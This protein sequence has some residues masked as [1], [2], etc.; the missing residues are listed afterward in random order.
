S[1]ENITEALTLYSV[2]NTVTELPMINRVEFLIDGES[3]RGYAYY[4]LTKPFTNSS[5]FLVE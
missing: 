3:V 1:H 4:D 5:E 2:V